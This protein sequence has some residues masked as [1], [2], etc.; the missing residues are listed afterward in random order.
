MN[1]TKLK[2]RINL[3]LNLDIRRKDFMSNEFPFPSGET[4]ESF[5]QKVI[6]ATADIFSIV[7]VNFQFIADLSENKIKDLVSLINNKGLIPWVDY[8]L[9]DIGTSNDHSLYNL[10]KMGFRG[11]TIHQIIGFEEGVQNI[12]KNAKKYKMDVISLAFMSHKG[13]NDYFNIQLF[14]RKKLFEKILEDGINWGVDGFVIGATITKSILMKIFEKFPNNR[15]F[16]ILMPGFGAQKGN[17]PILKLFKT[18]QN[19]I[20]LPSNGREII[21]AWKTAQS[22]FPD[23][24]RLA[25]LKFK[26]KVKQYL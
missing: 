22:S 10:N 21:Y 15:N 11:L 9:G 17:Y 1:K 14:N 25:A 4:R 24:C 5:T 23:A 26:Q 8:K 3:V 7:K 20:P 16:F 18:K 12:I 13:A 2:N 6:N 19:L